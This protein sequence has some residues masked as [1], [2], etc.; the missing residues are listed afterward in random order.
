[1]HGYLAT[2]LTGLPPKAEKE[3]RAAVERIREASRRLE[4]PAIEIY[5][6]GDHTHPTANPDFTPNQVYLIDRSRAS[7]FD[8]IILLCATPSYGVGQENEI[9]TQAG[10]PAVR[11]APRNLKGVSRMMSGSFIMAIDVAYE[12]SLEAGLVFDLDQLAAAFSSIRQVH[13]KL[14][15]LYKNLNGNTF[16]T[17]L[18][19]LVTARAGNVDRFAEDLGV[20]VAYVTALMEEQFAVSNPSARLLKR[21]S[22]L[23]GVS[24]SY[25]LGES[26]DAADPIYVESNAS[27]R[28][29][30][31]STPGVDGGLAL[32]MRDEWR[33]EFRERKM[34][35]NTTSF[36]REDPLM[37]EV[38]W[39]K[40]YRQLG[41]TTVRSSGGKKGDERA[42]GQLF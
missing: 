34:E 10:L 38:D 20:G 21:I 40:R 29:W 31:G 3:L 28:R 17:R 14:R 32:S 2:P 23:L 37:K 36:R 15:A 16:G 33:S 30:I 11:L 9:A 27:F 12:G 24:V 19:K 7:T 41:G 5:W 18:R 13:F 6:P 4:D 39:D 1:L 35:A 26:P 8:F 25:L 42:S 22:S